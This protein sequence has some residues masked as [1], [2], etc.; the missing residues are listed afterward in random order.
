MDFTCHGG[1]S[2]LRNQI[3]SYIAKGVFVLFIIIGLSF[4]VLFLSPNRALDHPSPQDDTIYYG[5]PV[6]KETNDTSAFSSLDRIVI[7]GV[8]Y[9]LTTECLFLFTCLILLISIEP[10]NIVIP[11]F[12]TF[13]R[14]SGFYIGYFFFLLGLIVLVLNGFQLSIYRR[15]KSRK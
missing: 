7:D 13:S 3:I 11:V 9:I 5:E 6:W 1:W 8:S 10:P 15:M 14:Y 2:S 12:I 4:L